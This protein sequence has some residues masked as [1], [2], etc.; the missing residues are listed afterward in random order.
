MSASLLFHFYA[1][2]FLFRQNVE[3]FV[4]VLLPFPS[5]PSPPSSPRHCHP[6]SPPYPYYSRTFPFPFA[7]RCLL[8]YAGK[9]NTVKLVEKD[10]DGIDGL[11]GELNG[12]RRRSTRAAPRGSLHAGRSTRVAPRR[13]LHAGRST[14]RG[15]RS[16]FIL[17]CAQY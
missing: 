12:A 8:G 5:L 3:P 9:T 15:R 14:G 13:S 16:F 17:T 11:V 10:D 4:F 1:S 2:A 7:P 6:K